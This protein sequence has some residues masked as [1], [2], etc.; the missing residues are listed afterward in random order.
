[1]S[2]GQLALART[3]LKVALAVAFFLVVFASP[4]PFLESSAAAPDPLTCTGYPEARVFL[5]SQS[6]WSDERQPFPGAHIHLGTCFPLVQEISGTVHFDI[7]GI[8]HNDPGE[9]TWLRITVTDD[10]NGAPIYLET[11]SWRCAQGDTCVQWFSVDIDTTKL[12]EDGRKEFRMTFNVSE[13]P[14][15]PNVGNRQFQTTRWHAII[16][17]GGGRPASDYGTTD[18]TGA[19]G[20]YTGSDYSN[21]RIRGNDA[22][23]AAYGTVCGVWSPTLRG[24]KA[25]FVVAVDAAN[26]GLDPGTIIYDGPGNNVWRTVEIDTTQFAEGPHKLFLRTDDLL[27]NG[28]SSGIFL[29]PFVVANL[30]AGDIVSPTISITSPSDGGAVSGTTPVQASASDN[31]CVTL[32]EFYVDGVLHSTDTSSPFSFTWDTTGLPDGSSHVL[33]ATAYDLAGNYGNSAP[34]TV[35]IVDSIPDSIPPV[36]SGVSASVTGTS[37]TITWTT[38]EPATSQVKYGLKRKYGQASLLD[39]TLVTSHSVTLTSLSPDRTYHYRALSV[40]SGGNSA[41]SGDHTFTTGASQANTPPTASFSSS[42]PTL[43][44]D[45]DGSSSQDPDGTIVSYDWNF[46]DG[47]IGSGATISHAYAGP[48][49]YTVTLVVADD[50]GASDSSSQTVT[51]GTPPSDVTV[52]DIAPDTM[53]AGTAV[54]VTVTGSGFVD[55]ATITFVNGKGPTPVASNVIVD[56]NSTIIALVTAGGGGPRRDRVWDVTVT[57]PDSSSDT[58]VGGLTITRP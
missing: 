47:N 13:T 10:P 50:D 17:N 11:L 21:V 34:V 27:P 26:H 6:W 54:I 58:L 1:M 7:R 40:D 2:T 35:T 20:W 3:S 32:V 38:D 55:G 30:S 25:R 51:V 53:Q 45:F 19:A 16:A 44:C 42:C 28:T 39:P 41:Q 56:N 31:G 23:E 52:T 29:L 43:N 18:R 5:E 9:V 22:V 37:A 57:N 4:S 24:E 36:I 14:D 15:G 46:G 48:G 8:L 33:T 49:T 12:A